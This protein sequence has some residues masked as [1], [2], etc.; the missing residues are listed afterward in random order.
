VK[1]PQQVAQAS[2]E[3]FKKAQEME[4][5]KQTAA[6]M[7]SPQMDPTKNPNAPEIG[8]QLGQNN[9]NQKQAGAPQAPPQ[10]NRPPT[11]Q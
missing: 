3:K 8:Q 11:P 9:P 6:M 5:T 7:N 2:E 1:D 10:G 4:M